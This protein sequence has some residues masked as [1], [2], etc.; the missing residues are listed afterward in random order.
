MIGDKTL[1][2]QNKAVDLAGLQQKIEDYLRSDGFTTQRSSPGPSGVLI[3]AKKGGWLA[4]IIA[5]DRALTVLISGQPNDCS[6]RIGIGKWIEH[7]AVTAV[8]TLLVSGLFLIVDVAETAWNLEIEHK[9][10]KAIESFVG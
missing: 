5:A 4:G 10:V 8:E 3:Q 1:K 2:F 7:L 9:L 6:V